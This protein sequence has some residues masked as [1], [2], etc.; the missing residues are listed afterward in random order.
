MEEAGTAE[1]EKQT[2]DVKVEKVEPTVATPEA[3]SKPRRR[4][5]KDVEVVVEVEPEPEPVVEEV[6]VEKPP[7]VI[8]P[9]KIF[10]ER[11]SRNALNVYY[12]GKQT[13]EAIT[14]E[15][16]NIFAENLIFKRVEDEREQ[17]RLR[18]KAIE[19]EAVRQMMKELLS[20][21]KVEEEE[22][23]EFEQEE[24]KEPQLKEGE[25]NT[26]KEEE[27]FDPDE[28]KKLCFQAY[29]DQYQ[30]GPIDRRI[31]YDDFVG[32]GEHCNIELPVNDIVKLKNDI[33]WK[34]VVEAKHG[35]LFEVFK[36]S[37]EKY[38]HIPNDMNLNW[39]QMGIED[40]FAELIE[41][42][43]PYEWNPIEFKKIIKAVSLNKIYTHF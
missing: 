24:D 27:I 20:Q 15:G 3:E 22:G 43:D 1:P 9:M 11:D 41:N 26:E 36:N 40:K 2:S 19:M 37:T 35:D 14:E 6:P 30:Q 4:R 17:K 7:L 32:F 29:A 34:R 8:G 18:L 23:E 13:L 38:K 21:N 16:R 42:L 10:N 39:R 33:F 28:L 5:K 25:Q 31:Q 12:P